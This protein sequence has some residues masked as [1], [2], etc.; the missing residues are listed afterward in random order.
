VNG[1]PLGYVDPT[2]LLRCRWVGIVL[3]C[4]WGP[5]PGFPPTG[6][7]ELDRVIRNPAGTMSS[8]SAEEEEPTA[9]PTPESCYDAYR[10]AID[11][12]CPKLKTRNARRQCYENAMTVY[13]NCLRECK[14][15]KK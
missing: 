3:Q 11:L 5:A 4:E 15:Q 2:G 12:I 8:S 7:P 9:M 14:P 10:Q 1:N 6:D 13:K